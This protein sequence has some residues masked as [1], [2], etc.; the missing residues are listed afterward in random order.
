MCTFLAW[1]YTCMHMCMYSMCETIDGH[2]LLSK[3]QLTIINQMLSWTQLGSCTWLKLTFTSSAHVFNHQK[4]FESNSVRK[5]PITLFI[6]CGLALAVPCATP[7]AQD[8]CHNATE[9]L[10]HKREKQICRLRSRAGELW[11]TGGPPSALLWPC[12]AH[13]MFT[14]LKYWEKLITSIETNHVGA[15][16]LPQE[17]AMRIICFSSC[18]FPIG[19]PPIVFR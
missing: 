17:L 2:Q 14:T 5:S 15:P 18:H 9:H 6:D 10:R 11:A 19:P 8:G 16:V 13:W 7:T 12:V 3:Q 1:L 4:L